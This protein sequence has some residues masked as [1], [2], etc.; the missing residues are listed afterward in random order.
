MQSVPEEE[1]RGIPGVDRGEHGRLAHKLIHSQGGQREE[2]D[3][4]DRS[5]QP[6]H[7]SRASPLDGKQREQDHAGDWHHPVLEGRAG[8][9]QALHSAEHGDGR[10][11]HAVAVEQRG[12]HHGQERHARHAADAAGPGAIAFGH[13][14]QQRQDATLAV[15]VGLHH[16]HHVFDGDHD[17]QRPEHERQDPEQVEPVEGLPAGGG[18]VEALFERVEGARADVTEDDAQRA[19]CELP[20]AG[21]SAVGRVGGVACG[22][23]G[24]GHAHVEFLRLMPKRNWA[25]RHRA[26]AATPATAEDT[27]RPRDHSPDG[28]AV[29]AASAIRRCTH[30]ASARRI[31]VS[32]LEMV[33]GAQPCRR[34]MSAACAPSV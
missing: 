1:L 24:L 10:R 22:V 12:A 31:K 3:E 9:G 25:D 28:Q 2:P 19:E 32:L 16:E 14:C 29:R 30:S 21:W 20:D 13:E 5:E 7:D 33:F 18:D 26:A 6:A 8:H 34:A 27:I 11:D 4:H 15:V 23:A 17:D